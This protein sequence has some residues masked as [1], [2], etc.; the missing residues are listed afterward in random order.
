MKSKTI[1]LSAISAGFV[2]IILTV[3]AYV[4][5]T[6]VFMLAVS[7]IFVLLPLY[8]NSYKGSILAFIAGGVIAFLVSGFNILSIV[9]PSYFGFFGIFPIV[10]SFMEGKRV[11]KIITHAVGL[12]WCV[13]AVY[14]IYLYYTFVM[15]SVLSGLPAWVTDNIWIVIGVLAIIFYFV[16][17]RFVTVMQRFANYYLRRIIK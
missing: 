15:G 4:E 11:K 6:D 14:A 3:G 16:F 12:I 1:A 13:I 2:A 5:F 7:S 10:K 9:F 8:F 17:E